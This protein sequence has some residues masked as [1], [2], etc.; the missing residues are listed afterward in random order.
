MLEPLFPADETDR[1]QALCDL[2]ILDTPAEERFDRITRIAADLFQVPIA[3]ISLVDTDRQWFKSKQGLNAT[4]TPR[5]VSFCGHAIL[6]QAPLVVVDAMM[7]DRFR[8]N[9]LVTGPPH[10]R[11][12]AG[13]PLKSV[14]KHHLGTLC[15]IDFQPREFSSDDLRRLAD[16]AAWAE[17]EINIYV[18]IDL[19]NTEMRDTFLRL[20]SHEL[21]TPMT[22][23]L[24]ALDMMQGDNISREEAKLFAGM[25]IE[26]AKRLNSLVEDVIELAEFQAAQGHL[27][28]EKLD[29][30]LALEGVLKDLSG[31]AKA[32]GVSLKLEIQ[33]AEFPYAPPKSLTRILKSLLDNAIRYSPEQTP[34]VIKVRQID[35]AWLR[36]SVED[37]GP[38]ISSDYLPRLFM[39]FGQANAGNNR[40]HEGC[41]LSLAIARRLAIAMGG[42]LGYE[43]HK[44]GGSIFYLDLRNA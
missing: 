32:K 1:I 8:D 38:G 42:R 36:V 2:R 7:D 3:L 40:L 39:P 13:I 41:G 33:K 31:G 16:L 12:Y 28:C 43:P 26:S 11:F 25:A 10:V 29:L 17:R 21:R 14:D 20:V 9:P 22:G 5:N 15:L 4:Q 37:R 30:A 19:A 6:G 35:E 44:E 27:Q 18:E 24:G 23:M 34:V